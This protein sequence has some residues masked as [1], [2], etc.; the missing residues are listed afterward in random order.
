MSAVTPEPRKGVHSFSPIFWSSVSTIACYAIV[1]DC[2]VAIILGMGARVAAALE[3]VGI[4]GLL[5]MIGERLSR[6]LAAGDAAAIGEGGDEEGVDG[7]VLL[8]FVQHLFHAFVD[9]GN[10]AHLNADHLGCGGGRGGGGPKGRGG[11]S[12][13][14]AG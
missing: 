12:G 14:R 7:S 1:P 8:E 2:G 6:H 4:V 13:G 10:G 3:G 9:E 11:G 5:A